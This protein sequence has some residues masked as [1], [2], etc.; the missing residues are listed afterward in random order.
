MPYTVEQV[1][2]F[3]LSEQIKEENATIDS[4][5]VLNEDQYPT[6]GSEENLFSYQKTFLGFDAM[7]SMDKLFRAG[8]ARRACIVVLPHRKGPPHFWS[9]AD[10]VDV[11]RAS[12]SRSTPTGWTVIPMT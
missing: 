7:V 4:S 1:R 2:F 11:R 5:A 3:L 12:I 10:F 8:G 9:R 6:V